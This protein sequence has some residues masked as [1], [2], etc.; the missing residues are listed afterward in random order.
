M[1]FRQWTTSVLKDYAVKGWVLD[2][3]RLK[4]GHIKRK[5]F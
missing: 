1:Q 2:K 4:M 3:E 5:L